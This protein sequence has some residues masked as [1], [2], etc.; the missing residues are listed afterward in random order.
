MA[1][2]KG[3]CKL[4]KKQS[5]VHDYFKRV[6][7]DVSVCEICIKELKMPTGNNTNLCSHLSCKNCEMYAEVIGKERSNVSG[8]FTKQ[9]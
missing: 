7:T 9:I 8:N 5:L 4:Y 1:T 3:E 6:G 2:S